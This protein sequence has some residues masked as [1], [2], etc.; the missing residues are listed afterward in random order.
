MFKLN[1]YEK[2]GFAS[3]GEIE[4]VQNKLLL[5]H[6]DYCLENSKF[7]HKCLK[8]I[9]KGKLITGNLSILPFTDKSDIAKYNEDFLA[10]PQEKVADIVLSSGTTGE[11]TK[12][13]YTE[14]SAFKVCYTALSFQKV[15]LHNYSS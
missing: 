1:T 3:P 6:L 4:K 12:I 13:A 11:P 5:K 7:Y 10:V 9:V 2:L 15:G 14:C 8:N